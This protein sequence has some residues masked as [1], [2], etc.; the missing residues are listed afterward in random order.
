MDFTESLRQLVV[1][2]MIEMNVALE[3]A[4]N[5]EALRMALKGIRLGTHGILS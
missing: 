4:H 1:N 3:N 5:E 2:G